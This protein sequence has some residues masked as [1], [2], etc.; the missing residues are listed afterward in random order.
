MKTM[1]D[2]NFSGLTTALDLPKMLEHIRQSLPECREEMELIDGKIDEVFYRPGSRCA[3]LYHLRFRH[4]ITGRTVGQHLSARLLQENDS[5][6]A[7]P[8]ELLSRY[9]KN[10]K[11]VIRTPMIYLQDLKILMHP[12]PI[13]PS[14]PWLLDALDPKT[15]R[16]YLNKLWA[17]KKMKVKKVR[18]KQLSYVPDMRAA[19]QYEILTQSKETGKSSSSHLIGKIHAFKEPSRLFAGAWALWKA[20]FGRLRLAPPVGYISPL[21]LTLQEKVEG[22]R[23]GILA[24]SPS[25]VRVMRETARQIAAMHSL[26]LPLSSHR[27]P[28]D[29]A[30]VVHRSGAV[31]K[32]IRPDLGSRIESLHRELAA[33]L[34]A[35]TQM[36]SPVHGDFQHTNVLVNGENIILIDLDEI[37]WGDP[38]VDVGRLLSSLRVP[39]LR[40]SGSLS[41]LQEARAAFLEEY[42]SIKREEEQRLGLFEASS[43]MITAASTFRQQRSQW[44]GEI[45]LILDEAERSLRAAKL[46]ETVFLSEETKTVKPLIPFEERRRW[47]SDPTYIQAVLDPHI[48][49]VYGAELRKCRVGRERQNSKRYLIHLNLSGRLSREKWKM[50]L[51]VM[52][53]RN[54]AGRHHFYRLTKLRQVLQEAPNAPILPRPVAYLPNLG[55]LVL[56]IPIGIRLSSLMASQERMNAARNVARSLAS[57]HNAKIESR[58][59]RRLPGHE[60]ETLDRLVQKLGKIR[61]DLSQEASEL[62]QNI[63][64]AM[65]FQADRSVPVVRAMRLD[66]ILCQEKQIA[67]A[68][69]ERFTFSHPLTDV[70]GLVAQLLLRGMKLNRLAEFKET[71]AYFISCYEEASGLSQNGLW[72]FQAW[73]L[74][75]MA[76]RQLEQ[77]PQNPFAQP[78][79]DLAEKKNQLTI[80]DTNPHGH[81]NF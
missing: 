75:R 24:D 79:L 59:R 20:A 45:E 42:L 43:L 39:A 13:D 10:P 60:M 69:I 19:L 74:L 80:K 49:K 40:V 46:K 38:F 58:S 35:R 36:T 64:N 11:H 1:V 48:Q 16:R 56:E 9:R 26:S 78:L 22:K 81:H 70:G 15:A 34:E 27:T 29:E 21:R 67:F 50:G 73:A 71:A 61:P 32:F 37:A 28:K 66:H 3:L 4:R 17:K 14:L 76:Y 7:P 55:G 23:L 47:I 57:L 33:Q 51:Q 41:G 2:E 53:W 63:K 77:N 30:R 44:H 18:I 54:H 72:A 62:F 5:A 25:F 12:F 8:Q 52:I 6:V 31:L 68:N 65:P